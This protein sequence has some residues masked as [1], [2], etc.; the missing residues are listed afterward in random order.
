VP[1]LWLVARYYLSLK[2]AN[3]LFSFL[4]LTCGVILLTIALAKLSF[5]YFELYFL[6]W[7]ANFVA[8]PVKIPES[9][10]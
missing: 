9:A 7:K 2:P 10:Y 5:D 3:S 6:K 1:L 4:L 8:A